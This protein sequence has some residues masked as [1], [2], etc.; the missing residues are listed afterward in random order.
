MTHGTLYI[1]FA[2]GVPMDEVAGTLA[3]ARI[4]TEAL[5]GA[6][7]LALEPDPRLDR[8]ARRLGID[9]STDCGRDLA[10][11][12][13]GLARREFGAAAVRFVAADAGEGA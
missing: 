3:L 4:S 12:F 10:T 1:R 9:V 2:D 5:H 8:G 7:R 13:F 11:L 6:D